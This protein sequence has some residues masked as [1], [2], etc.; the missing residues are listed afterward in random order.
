MR[1]VT[2]SWLRYTFRASPSATKPKT[3]PITIHLIVLYAENEQSDSANSS[4]GDSATVH[5]I[6]G[7]AHL[8]C[9]GNAPDWDI[10]AI[11]DGSSTI[12]PG[13]IWY[14]ALHGN[15]TIDLHLIRSLGF[16]ELLVR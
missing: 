14:N 9:A 8:G 11:L 16:P 7:K 13:T 2:R 6:L 5:P 10:G 15:L 3:R 1:P 4:H 12:S